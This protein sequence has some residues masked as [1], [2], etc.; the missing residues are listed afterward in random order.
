MGKPL[1]ADLPYPE[2][3]CGC[4]NKRYA[5]LLMQDYAGMA[6]ELTAVLQYT[7]D[8]MLLKES[9][10]DVSELLE[11]I[12]FTEMHHMRMLGDLVSD[13]GGDP[14]YNGGSCENCKPF[15][16]CGI[17][18]NK[19]TAL[20]LMENIAG[21]RKAIA[22]YTRRIE[23][24]QDEYVCAVLHRIIMDEETHIAALCQMMEKYC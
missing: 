18:Y 19:T 21:E 5:D 15:H 4:T 2:V 8:S 9:A 3:R 1:T 12:S 14:R 7:Y 10:P 20:I 13:L 16:T 11:D 17:T 24:I 6:S 23:V 22:N